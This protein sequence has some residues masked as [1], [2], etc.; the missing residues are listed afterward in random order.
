MDKNANNKK[1]LIRKQPEKQIRND[2][3]SL[4]LNQIKDTRQITNRVQQAD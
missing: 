3:D 2:K 4:K 1:Y